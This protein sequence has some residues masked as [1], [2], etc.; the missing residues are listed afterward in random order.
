MDELL[1]KIGLVRLTDQD[2]AV[3]LL[4]TQSGKVVYVLPQQPPLLKRLI[5]KDLY[6]ITP[7]RDRLGLREW[8]AK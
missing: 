6:V 2:I 1:W 8:L 3:D 4:S 7:P 5:Q